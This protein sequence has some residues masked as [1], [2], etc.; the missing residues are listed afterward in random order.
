[1]PK[2]LGR[3]RPNLGWLRLKLARFQPKLGRVRPQLGPKLIK[4]RPRSSESWPKSAKRVAPSHGARINA[5]AAHNGY[6]REGQDAL[7]LLALV[8]RHERPGKAV[9]LGRQRRVG[10][11]FLQCRQKGLRNTHQSVHARVQH[12]SPLHEMVSV[13]TG[14]HLPLPTSTYLQKKQLRPET[15]V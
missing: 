3:L 2:S 13:R 5:P 9:G 14:H 10:T 8:A 11:Q 7:L 6:G 1:M 4:R 15:G 12:T